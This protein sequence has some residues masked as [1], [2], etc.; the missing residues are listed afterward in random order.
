MA[1][2]HLHANKWAHADIKPDQFL[3]DEHG[4]AKLIDFGIAEPLRLEKQPEEWPWE[5]WSLGDFF[6][7]LVS[8]FEFFFNFS[9]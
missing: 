9:K 1:V 3:L 6:F 5:S 7:V 4:G 2:L 8:I